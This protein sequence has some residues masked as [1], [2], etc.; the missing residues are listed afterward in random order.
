VNDSSR[1]FIRKSANELIKRIK[2]RELLHKIESELISHLTLGHNARL[3]ISGYHRRDSSQHNHVIDTGKGSPYIEVLNIL[4]GEENYSRNFCLYGSSLSLTCP[5]TGEH[6]TIVY[7]GLSQNRYEFD[8]DGSGYPVINGKGIVRKETD[9]SRMHRKVIAFGRLVP[10]DVSAISELDDVSIR[11]LG[12]TTITILEI[13]HGHIDGYI[14]ETK[15]WNIWWAI[16]LSEQ[17]GIYLYD[18]NTMEP[19][20]NQIQE[21]LQAPEKTLTIACF[22]DLS[23]KDQ[24]MNVVKSYSNYL[25]LKRRST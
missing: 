20:G 24:F 11:S 19:I 1:D 3:I 21:I 16:F 13:I 6:F 23:F 17:L 10:F 25:Q 4:D 14:N 8:C 2:K 18:L 15:I 7:D 22:R 5:E 9:T 12:S